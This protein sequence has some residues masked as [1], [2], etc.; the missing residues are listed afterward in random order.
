[1]LTKD[2]W[3]IKKAKLYLQFDFEKVAD[4]IERKAFFIKFD[5]AV[6]KMSN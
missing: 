3:E 5:I 1:M 2:L 6:F 4:E